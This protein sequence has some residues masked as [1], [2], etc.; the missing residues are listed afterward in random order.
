MSMLTADILMPIALFSG[1]GVFCGVVLCFAARF[2][3]VQEHPLVEELTS[4]L[5]GINCGACG[6]AGCSDYAKALA[7]SGAE[8]TLCKAV[9]PEALAKI[10]AALGV[11]AVAGERRVAIVLCKGGAS[12]AHERFLYNGVADCAAAAAVGG[13]FKACEYG[14]LGLGTC[15]RVCPVGAIEITADR[16]AFVHPELCVGCGLC[17]KACPRKLIELAPD[18]R[19]IHVLCSSRDKGP[20]VKKKCKVGCIGCSLCAKNAPGGA[21]RMEGPLAV[22]DYS[23]ALE[24]EEVIAK[25]PQH[26]IEKRSLS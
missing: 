10:A 5:P 16:L 23:V 9:T 22:V 12:Q 7:L 11:E 8:T 20:V 18:S 2:F 21:I 3:A 25:C 14:C 15:S 1:V 6:F 13:G 4:L 24:S 17:V 26:T 19:S